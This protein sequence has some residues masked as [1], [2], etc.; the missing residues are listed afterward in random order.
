MLGRHGDGAGFG[1]GGS[2][3]S[4]LAGTGGQQV[5]GLSKEEDKRLRAGG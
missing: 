3:F 4:R 5:L 2:L 1:F